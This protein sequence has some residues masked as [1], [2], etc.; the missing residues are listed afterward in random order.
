M[1]QSLFF[2]KNKFLHILST[3]AQLL[4]Q[5]PVLQSWPK[6]DLSI[7]HTEILI[8]SG[9]L[10]SL[11]TSLRYEVL[12]GTSSSRDIPVANAK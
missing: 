6:N 7:G 3:H 12:W 5:S 4:P 2:F 11:V 8:L 10:I 9:G 1:S